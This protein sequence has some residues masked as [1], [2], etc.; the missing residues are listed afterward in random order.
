MTWHY[1]RANQQAGPVAEEELQGLAASGALGP[2]DLVW[3][4]GMAQWSPAAEVLPALF[5]ARAVPP[6]LPAQPVTY[7]RHEPSLP[8]AADELG[9]NAGVRW[10]IPVGR[11]PLAIVAG[12]LGLL[13]I[14]LFVA[15]IALA[16]GVFA[17][18]DIRKHP[19]RHG[20]GRAI[21]GVVMG[22]LGTLLLAFLLLRA[23]V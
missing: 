16:V 15:P 1:A 8:P 13:S 2:G 22:T 18:L 21:F 9:Q 17:I 14:L 11:S 20:M 4:D 12:Y 5:P 7:F 23:F 3:R 19:G 6:P 10:L